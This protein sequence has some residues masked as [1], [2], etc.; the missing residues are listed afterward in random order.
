MSIA[1]DRILEAQR[2]LDLLKV[3][4]L[5]D[6]F[7]NVRG[8]DNTEEGINLRD[9]E[10]AFTN[11]YSDRIIF[12]LISKGQQLLE[13]EKIP[14]QQRT[15]QQRNQIITLRKEQKKFS[16]NFNQF[17]S[18]AEVQ[19]IIKQLQTE[20]DKNATVTFNLTQDVK[21][22]EALQTMEKQGIRAAILYPFIIEDR[23]ELIL[24][25]AYGPPIR[26][27]I[28]LNKTELNRTI[29]LARNTIK[30]RSDIT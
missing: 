24:V 16:Q 12:Q 30:T 7:N 18:S 21:L 26:K 29:L 10:T 14:A 5:D 4:E 28:N 8:N 17:L 25:N 13:L 1:Q 19:K 3:Q 23:L 20:I 22:K 6:Y 2:V 27:T 11:Q 15:E 9:P